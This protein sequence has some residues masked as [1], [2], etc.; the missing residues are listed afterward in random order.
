MNRDSLYSPAGA[1]PKKKK[2]MNMYSVA[3]CKKYNYIIIIPRGSA[4]K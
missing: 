3:F 4:W 1:F 2:N